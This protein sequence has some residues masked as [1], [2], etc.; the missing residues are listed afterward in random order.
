[1]KSFNEYLAKTGEIGYVEDLTGSI[2]F[3]SGLPN[4]KSSELVVFESGILGQILSL[5]PQS[6]EILTFSKKPIRAGERIAR[7]DEFLQIPAGESLLGNIVDSF[8]NSLN[9]NTVWKITEKR[10]IDVA[11]VGILPRRKIKKTFETGISIVD[12]MVPIGKGQ[13]ELVIGDRKTGKTSFLLQTILHRAQKGDICIYAAIGKKK[14]DIKRA[15][16]F[17]EK[18]GVMDKIIIVAQ[19]SEDPPGQIYLVPYSAMTLAE[20]FKDQG[21]DVCLVLDDLLTHAKFYREIALLG[22]RFPGRNSYPGNIFHIH[23]KLI[24]RAGNFSVKDGENAITC[25]P[26]VETNQGDL[27]GYIQTNLMSMTDGH[28]Y[29]DTNLFS[30]GR[31]PSINPFLS[32]TRVGMQTQSSLKRSINRELIR[33]LSLYERMQIFVHFGAETNETT[34]TTIKTGEKVLKFFDQA[35]AVIIPENI[36]IVFFTLLWTNVIDENAILYKQK[37]I[38]LYKDGGSFSDLVDGLVKN[39]NSLNELIDSVTS[40]NKVLLSAIKL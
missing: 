13:R 30:Q 40:K 12:L 5:N 7:T 34:K 33:F 23:A 35:A 36:A 9:L 1:M 8:G 31:R 37:A 18:N 15:R 16:E 17:F 29:F 38:S 28:L 39:A 27:S 11:P 24:E 22:K 3:G 20:Y 25:L 19:S 21:R 26:V 2:V 6:L 10:P 4:A 32:V 14:I